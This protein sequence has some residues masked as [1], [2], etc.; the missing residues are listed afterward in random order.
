[1]KELNDYVQYNNTLFKRWAHVYDY[2]AAFIS[3]TR[4]IVSQQ[5]DLPKGSK[6]LD[7]ACGTGTQAILFAKGGYAVTGVDLSPDMLRIAKRKVKKDYDVRFLECDASQLPFDDNEFSFSTIS[8]ALHDMPEKIAVRVLKEMKRVTKSKGKIVI[9][10]YHSSPVPLIRIVMN[11]IVGL[12]E[13]DYYHEFMKNG[14]N[15]YLSKVHLK[16]EKRRL[17][18]LGNF[19]IVLSINE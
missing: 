15:H 10:D 6:I 4:K 13:S 5:T 18:F 1:M 3:P 16:I 19:Q 12:W 17:G 8:F 11:A 2:F 14:L 7:V 9:V